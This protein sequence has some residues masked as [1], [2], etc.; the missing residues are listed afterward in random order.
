MVTAPASCLL[1][2]FV[3]NG[4]VE[5]LEALGGEADG[6]GRDGG[7]VDWRARGGLLGAGAERPSEK[8]DGGEKGSDR[9]QAEDF[10]WIP[11]GR[12]GGRRPGTAPFISNWQDAGRQR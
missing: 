12:C 3:L 1:V 8:S 10:H 5:A 4:G 6:L 7:H 9:E 2:D 11:F